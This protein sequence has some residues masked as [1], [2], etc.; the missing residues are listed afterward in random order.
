M[1]RAATILG[2]AALL[3]AGAAAATLNFTN[4]ITG[5]P[6]DLSDAAPEG[7]DTRAVKHFVQTGENL[8]NEHAQCLP[9]GRELYLSACSGCHGQ[10]A[11]GKLG[12]GLNDSY[13]TYPKNATDQGLFET[14]FGGASGQMGPMYGA[15]NLNEMLLAMA[16]V[17]HLYK[18]DPKGAGW[19][20]AEQRARFKPYVEVKGVE[21]APPV[22][23]A[24]AKAAG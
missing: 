19:L 8:Y 21:H 16:W 20:T 17:R 11:E 7:R 12:P 2:L 6:L 15:L 4:T 22:E 13:W 9:E 3:A 5:Q 14:L 10:V 1:R 18:E 23:G 24:C